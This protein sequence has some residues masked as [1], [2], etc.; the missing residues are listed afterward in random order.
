VSCDFVTVAEKRMGA[1]PDGAH[2]PSVD[3]VACCLGMVEEQ[4]R[5][6]WLGISCELHYS[7]VSSTQE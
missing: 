2:Q 4:G 1:D 3:D 6:L 5:S 7:F